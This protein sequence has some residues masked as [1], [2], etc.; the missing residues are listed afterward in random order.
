MKRE[1]LK[2][3]YQKENGLI[4]NLIHFFICKNWFD[5]TGKFKVGDKVKYNWM[6]KVMIASVVKRKEDKTLTVSK[7][8]CNGQNVEFEECS[9]SSAFWLR[10]AYWWEK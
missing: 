2:F 7:V 6:A 1:K 10:K 3:M 5:N 9:G 8:I 4:F